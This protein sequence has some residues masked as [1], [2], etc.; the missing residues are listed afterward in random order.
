MAF[1]LAARAKARAKAALAK[2]IARAADSRAI[3]GIDLRA[4][5][6]GQIWC[7]ARNSPV[8]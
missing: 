8:K 6:A 7:C 2:A 3:S 4:R 1:G 5:N